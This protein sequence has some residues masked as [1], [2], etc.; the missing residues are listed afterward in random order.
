MAAA[1]ILDRLSREQSPAG[2]L[3]GRFVRIWSAALADGSRGA[4]EFIDRTWR[5]ADVLRSAVGAVAADDPARAS[6]FG[7]LLD[8]VLPMTIIGRMGVEL[9]PFGVPGVGLSADARA[10]WVNEGAMVPLSGLKLEKHP[11]L[12][13]HRVSAL[14]VLTRKALQGAPGLDRFLLRNLS[15]LVAA[16]IDRGF[17]D[18]ANDGS[19]AAPTS[20]VHADSGFPTTAASGNAEADVATLFE[21]FAGSWPDARVILH[22]LTA[23][24]LGGAL[25]G[26]GLDVRLGALGGVLAGVP[27]IASDLVPRDSAGAS[28]ITIVDASALAVALAVTDLSVADQA[29]VVMDDAP[30]GNSTTPTGLDASG[31]PLVSLWQSGS[32]G[33]MASASADWQV[34]R[35]GAVAT[36]TGARYE[37]AS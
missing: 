4:D 20:I 17:I 32:V 12:R 23:V 30:S 27:A 13:P 2:F 16:E 8:M 24:E 3:A 34:R 31:Q 11:A 10:A 5:Q 37:V 26:S 21:M 14:D 25:R 36:L 15:R 35:A 33:V 18:P 6:V 29:T 22:P 7:D 28:S 19:G 9:R 1:D